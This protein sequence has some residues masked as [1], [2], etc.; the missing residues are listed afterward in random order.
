[1]KAQTYLTPRGKEIFNEIVDCISDPKILQST[2]SFQLSA[3]ANAFDIHNRVAEIMNATNTG[4]SQLS[5]KTGYSQVSPEFTVWKS[6]LDYIN[7]N[8]SKF[9]L[10]PEARE[11]LQN[12]WSKKE[13]KEDSIGDMMSID[14][15]KSFT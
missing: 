2:D 6:S 12:L 13:K 10:D 9:G 8:A 3:L 4:Y 5:E 7:K 1:M 15:N 14:G 11:K